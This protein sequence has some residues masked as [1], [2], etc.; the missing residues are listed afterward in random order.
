MRRR[1]N[2]GRL[3]VTTLAPEDIRYTGKPYSKA[4]GAY[5]FNAREYDPQL[6][7]WTTADPSGF[8]DGVNNRA[9]TSRPINDCDSTGLITSQGQ[10]PLPDDVGWVVGNTVPD[11]NYNGQQGTQYE[12]LLQ[13][14]GWVD[15]GVGAAGDVGQSLQFTGSVG[16]TQTTTFGA[17]L[18]FSKTITFGAAYTE[19]Q[20]NSLGGAVTAKKD[21]VPNS[22]WQVD[23]LIAQANFRV[24]TRRMEL[25][26]DGTWRPADES[27]GGSG[28][29]ENKLGSKGVYSAVA[30]LEW[31]E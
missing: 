17:S 11:A 26:S 31:F 27:A 19:A 18:G 9:Y 16:I 23:I 29:E 25:D 4:L 5:V 14:M 30:A 24:A 15:T 22:S 7:R 8:P 12:Y 20:G 2:N 3:R 6:S 10:P 21:G 13:Y 28:S 1:R